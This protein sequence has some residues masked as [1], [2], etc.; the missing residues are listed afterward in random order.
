M[1]IGTRQ[2]TLE[3][4]ADTGRVMLRLY[5]GTVKPVSQPAIAMPIP[6]STFQLSFSEMDNLVSWWNNRRVNED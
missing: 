5:A 3:V 4:G 1:I 6:E 2:G